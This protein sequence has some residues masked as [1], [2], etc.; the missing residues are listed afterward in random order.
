M[1]GRDE[2]CAPAFCLIKRRYVRGAK[3][4]T[5]GCNVLA[6]FTRLP[7]FLVHNL[8]IDFIKSPAMLPEH[9]CPVADVKM[10]RDSKWKCA[11]A[12]VL[13]L[14]GLL[15]K[16]RERLV[17]QRQ[18]RRRRA[19]R[20]KTRPRLRNLHVITTPVAPIKS[21]L[22]CFPDRKSMGGGGAGGG[23]SKWKHG[24]KGHAGHK[25]RD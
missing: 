18:T 11:A 1:C 14:T 19:V 4:K 10:L 15:R 13:A 17:D 12:A 7:F 3:R 20:I 9:S 2:A 6:L 23:E 8:G 24:A 21:M 5:D 25:R 22:P 16:F